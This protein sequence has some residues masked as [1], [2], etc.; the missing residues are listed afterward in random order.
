MLRGHR[1]GRNG[2]I[3]KLLFIEATHAC[4]A[5]TS[6]EAAAAVEVVQ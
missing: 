5:R 4:E 1:F 3:E 2:L 6:A